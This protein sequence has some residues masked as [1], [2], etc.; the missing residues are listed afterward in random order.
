MDAVASVAARVTSAR[1]L[2]DAGQ[3]PR[4]C[5][6]LTRVKQLWRDADASLGAA[7]AKA[8]SLQR[9]GCA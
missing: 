6:L 8:D 4:A 5:A 2:L 1:L 7:L 9:A 3:A